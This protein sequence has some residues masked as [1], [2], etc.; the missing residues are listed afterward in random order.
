MNTQFDQLIENI[1]SFIN[2]E[3]FNREQSS[4][5]CLEKL[6]TTKP[7][8][9]AIEY[10]VQFQKLPETLIRKYVS[11]FNLAQVLEYQSVSEAFCQEFATTSFLVYKTIVHKQI[12]EQF[13]EILIEQKN[14]T[15]NGHH[16]VQYQVLSE[17]FIIKHFKKMHIIDIFDYQTVSEQFVIDHLPYNAAI[18]ATVIYKQKLSIEFMKKYQEFIPWSIA[19]GSQKLSM[20]LINS[21]T[22]IQDLLFWANISKYQILT[23]E[24]IRSNENKLHWPYLCETQPL[25]IEIIDEMIN[26]GKIRQKDIQSLILNKNIDQT[27]LSSY[28]SI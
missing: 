27:L 6:L 21:L 19:S 18:W 20:E 9:Q 28:L 13:A 10:I 3:Q 5:E 8:K 17:P 7:S 11:Q 22:Y 4:N 16:L 23:E 15:S 12:S 25:S 26:L 1:N 2:G 14:Q 24:F